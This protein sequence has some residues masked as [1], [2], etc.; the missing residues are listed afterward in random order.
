[1]S[2][3][4]QWSCFVYHAD[5]IVARRLNK[6]LLLL[7]SRNSLQY[8]TAVEGF[9]LTFLQKKYI[10]KTYVAG[11]IALTLTNLNVFYVYFVCILESSHVFT[12]FQKSLM[13]KDYSSIVF[14]K[15]LITKKYNTSH[16]STSLVICCCS[17]RSSR[18]LVSLKQLKIER[19]PQPRKTD[20]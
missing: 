15:D 6:Y 13:N 10:W 8:S 16:S 7:S 5:K 9:T 18:T 4:T 17:L 1:M 3:T 11:F 14:I 19:G 12:K 2:Y 20:T